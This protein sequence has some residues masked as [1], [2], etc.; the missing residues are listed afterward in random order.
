MWQAI[1]SP[2]DTIKSTAAPATPEFKAAQLQCDPGK[3][4]P[5]RTLISDITAD[6]T[7]ELFLYVNDAVLLLPRL[8]KVFYENNS[9]RAK[10]TVTRM[11]ADEIIRPAPEAGVEARLLDASGQRNERP[12]DK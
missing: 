12:R 10:V 4:R 7:G 2:W 1:T 6:A 5:N 11:T 9:G 8:T 3:P